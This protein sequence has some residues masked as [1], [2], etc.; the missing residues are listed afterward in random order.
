MSSEAIEAVVLSG[1]FTPLILQV[2]TRVKPEFFSTPFNKKLYSLAS[3]FYEKNR[4]PISKEALTAIFEKE[5]HENVLELE[6]LLSKIPNK[7]DEALLLQRADDLKQAFQKREV[8]GLLEELKRMSN[9]DFEAVSG[10]V[11]KRLYEIESQSNTDAQFQEG[12]DPKVVEKQKKYLD[13]QASQDPQKK[14]FFGLEKIDEY[15]IP[16]GPKLLYTYAAPTGHGKTAVLL[17]HAY[18]MVVHLKR[19]VVFANCEMGEE[20][21]K[22]AFYAL[23]AYKELGLHAVDVSEIMSGKSPE[24][25]YLALKS[26]VDKFASG[27]YGKIFFIEAS[28]LTLPEL[29]SKVEELNNTVAPIDALFVDY[30]A[31]LKN[32]S[33]NKNDMAFS[34][35]DETFK[36]AEYMKNSFAKGRGLF[37]VTGHQINRSGERRILETTKKKGFHTVDLYMSNEARH[38]SDAIIGFYKPQDDDGNV[39]S[40]E[41]LNSELLVSIMKNRWGKAGMKPFPIG[42]NWRVRALNHIDVL[43]EDDNRISFDKEPEMLDFN[44]DD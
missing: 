27:G 32:M 31:A 39:V 3:E 14:Y 2:R 38:K 23:Y 26:A 44:K 13:E 37:I 4:C 17:N 41:S 12:S 16:G 1:V 34:Q 7:V 18:H 25:I 20:Q 43:P 8:D 6:I 33:K 10:S 40:E 29:H 36:Y 11:K 35:M 28:G 21:M 19:N 15:L 24:N 9:F 30:F 22:M 42:V 5:N